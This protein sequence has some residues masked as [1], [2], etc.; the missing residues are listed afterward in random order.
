MTSTSFINRYEQFGR[1]WIS[2]EGP[3][4]QGKDLDAATEA[5]TANAEKRV[6][7]HID[8]V[9]TELLKGF[10]VNKRIVAT[11]GAGLIPFGKIL[12]GAVMNHTFIDKVLIGF[13]LHDQANIDK[14]SEDL[15]KICKLEKVAQKVRLEALKKT[16][17][18]TFKEVLNCSAEEH[19]H[20]I[21]I[22]GHIYSVSSGGYKAYSAC[23]KTIMK[24]MTMAET[25]HCET[26]VPLALRRECVF[27][28]RFLVDNADLYAE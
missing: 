15:R 26:F 20:F 1:D 22:I 24:T 23:W 10:S 14:L 21:P 7:D 9:G 18:E 27:Q 11:A 3:K 2:K 6:K 4:W 17:E 13:A 19:A 12:V 8:D 16:A 5:L 25:V 28:L